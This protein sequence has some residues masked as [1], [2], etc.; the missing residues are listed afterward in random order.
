MQCFSEFSTPSPIVLLSLFRFKAYFH[1]IVHK[2][3]C[4]YVCKRRHRARTRV[5]RR[6][7]DRVCVCDS[8]R[9]FLLARACVCAC[10]CVCDFF[11]SIP[12]NVSMTISRLCADNYGVSLSV[13]W[14]QSA[15]L[16]LRV[17][18]CNVYLS[19]LWSQ[20]VDLLLC[21]RVT[22]TCLWCDQSHDFLLCE[23]VVFT[24]LCQ[25]A[26]MCERLCENLLNANMIATTTILKALI[27]FIKILKSC[28]YW[29]VLIL[30]ILAYCEREGQRERQRERERV[31]VCVCVC[32]CVFARIRARE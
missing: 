16:L 31:C 32:V 5:L 14:S 12:V 10:A 4:A 17:Y 7:C 29:Q 23:C 1:V 20:S 25:L 22:C 24:C 3:F 6:S 21:V 11:F 27:G 28:L 8:V 2:S 30:I 26:C 19:V 13:G 15:D 18:M 9:V